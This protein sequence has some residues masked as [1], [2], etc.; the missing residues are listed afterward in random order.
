MSA[1]LVPPLVNGMDSVAEL[2]VCAFGWALAQNIHSNSI[3]ESRT[4]MSAIL[5][6]NTNCLTVWYV[7]NLSRI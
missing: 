7:T 4:R 3:L 1:I 5:I 2:T 6:V